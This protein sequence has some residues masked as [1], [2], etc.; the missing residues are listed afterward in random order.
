[1]SDFN[2]GIINDF[3]ANAGQMPSGPFQGKDLLLLT[4]VGGKTGLLRTNPLAY[5]RDGDRYV[6]IASKGGADTHPAWYR[7]LLATPTATIEVGPDTFKVRAT[8]VHGAERRRL[9]D[10]QAKV[11]P[12][13]ADYERKTS[14]TIPVMALERIS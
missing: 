14:R 3:R 7:N 1:M 11:M 8:E 13:F 6:I 10:G 9:Y 12:G 2:H 4:T 5:T